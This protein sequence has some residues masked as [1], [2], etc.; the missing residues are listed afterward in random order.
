MA[1]ATWLSPTQYEN[2]AAA[3]IIVHHLKLSLKVMSESNQSKVTENKVSEVNSENVA[4][5]VRPI[6][7]GL[8]C[9][10]Y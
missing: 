7:Q 9:T 5:R 4:N 2:F 8:G 1:L 3:A 10:Q 6:A